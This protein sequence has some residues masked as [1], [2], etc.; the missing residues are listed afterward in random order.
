MS[1]RLSVLPETRRPVAVPRRDRRAA[2]ARALSTC[3]ASERV[4][5]ALLLFERL[6]PAEAASVLGVPAP[7]IERAYASL[8][9]QL[10]LSLRGCSRIPASPAAAPRFSTPTA[11]LRRAS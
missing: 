8:L 3:A 1:A 6:T 2:V 4:L 10:R 11:R 9:S 5:L 7:R